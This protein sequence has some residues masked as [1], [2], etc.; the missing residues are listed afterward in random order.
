M[1]CIFCPTNGGYLTKSGVVH[2]PDERT[3][4]GKLVAIGD[5]LIELAKSNKEMVKF[6]EQLQK[7]IND[8][9]DELI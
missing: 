3:K 7:E 1:R 8:L 9:I 2:S 5:K 6:D 4:M